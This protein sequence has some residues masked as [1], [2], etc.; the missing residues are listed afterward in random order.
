MVRRTISFACGE[1][2]LT[3]QQLDLNRKN[4]RKPGDSGSRVAIA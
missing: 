1:P 4:A 2:L 3:L